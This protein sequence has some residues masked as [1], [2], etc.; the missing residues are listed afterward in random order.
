[1]S[2]HRNLVV[3]ADIDDEYQEIVFR[4]KTTTRLSKLKKV[5]AERVGQQRCSLQFKIGGVEIK[6]EDTVEDLNCEEFEKIFVSRKQVMRTQKQ[7]SQ[8]TRFEEQLKN[9][10]ETTREIL[11]KEIDLKKKNLKLYKQEKAGELE[12]IEK[13]MKAL[14][15]SMERLMNS[16][17]EEKNIHLGEIEKKEEEIRKA[18]SDLESFERSYLPT[19]E[20]MK[21]DFD[22]P[23]C[24]EL[25]EPP[26]RIFQCLNGHLIC[27]NCKE[28]PEIR[29][30]PVCRIHLGSKKQ[31]LSRNLALEKLGEFYLGAK[32]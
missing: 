30:C 24:Y 11:V 3:I 13:A 23:V 15:I 12:P 10:K 22:C 14:Q 31:N 19:S 21:K 27:Q 29:A 18:K 1:M 2:V 5:F 32:I 17:T 26:R 8:I 7:Q 4:I 25:M 9:M 20:T 6:D 16:V 28:R